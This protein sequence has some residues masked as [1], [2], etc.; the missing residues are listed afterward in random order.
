[1]RQQERDN[2]KRKRPNYVTIS[3]AEAQKRGYRPVT[4][5]YSTRQ[6]DQCAMLD[7]VIRDFYNCDVILVRLGNRN[8]VEVWRKIWDRIV[9]PEILPVL[10][11]KWRHKKSNA[12]R[13]LPMTDMQVFQYLDD[14]IVFRAKL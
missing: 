1:M 11:G 13:L 7:K 12:V 9:K 5:G 8:V 3:V 10:N 2:R 4:S 6:F 14:L